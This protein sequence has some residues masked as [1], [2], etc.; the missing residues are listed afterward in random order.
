MYTN[1]I[2]TLHKQEI[3][4][5]FEADLCLKEGRSLATAEV[6]LREVAF[7][8]D[9]MQLHQLLWGELTPVLMEEY[10]LSREL[11]PV[12]RTKVMS[13]LR[14]FMRFLVYYELLTHNPMDLVK[15][16]RTKRK[17]PQVIT[18]D[19]VDKLLE[20][21]DITTPYGLRDRTLYELMYSCGLRISEAVNLDKNDVIFSEGLVRVI[22]KGNKQ[23]LLPLG[24]RASDWIHKY[25]EE[26]RPKL[27][28]SNKG[29]PY[30]RQNEHALFLN[31]R[32]KR[33]S[34]KGIWLNLKKWAAIEGIELNVHTLRHSFATHLLKHGAD[35]R[36]VQELLGHV[37]IGTTEIYTHL[38]RQDLAM[39]HKKFHPRSD[40]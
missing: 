19:Q 21:C 20:T 14:K 17:S 15:R 9:Y 40:I 16:P 36:V 29:T 30:Q 37:D 22:G 31:F 26:A 35:L 11:S 38:S 23:R 13:A 25:L 12:S 5:L 8:I 6:Y 32:G 1:D 18:E 34:R 7:F 10:L 4:E 27:L 3:L 28:E 39:A 24:D 33:L 2:T